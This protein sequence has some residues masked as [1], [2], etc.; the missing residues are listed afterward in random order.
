MKKI[1]KSLLLSILLILI[2]ATTSY[3]VLD[4]KCVDDASN[5]LD[6]KLESLITCAN[7][8]LYE[9]TGA[10]I[11]VV[12]KNSLAGIDISEYA[13]TY[14]AEITKSSINTDKN[15]IIVI[16]KNDRISDI[17]VSNGLSTFITKDETN[18]ILSNYMV[19]YFQKSNWNLGVEKGFR[20]IV[21]LLENHYSIDVIVDT[22]E[23][24]GMSKESNLELTNGI[25]LL[26]YSA[27]FVI[28]FGGLLYTFTHGS[29]IKAY[30]IKREG[31]PYSG[32]KYKKNSYFGFFPYSE[33]IQGEGRRKEEK[34]EKH[35]KKEKKGVSR[36]VPKKSKTKKAK[37]KDT[38]KD[39]PKDFFDIYKY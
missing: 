8:D 10:T 11:T 37:G 19:P 30:G 31:N 1:S 14:E 35:S 2:V 16:S 33:E 13:K 20:E 17:F 23:I 36:I 25:K 39:L 32:Y 29:S 4:I 5:I 6:K 38:D 28:F 7:N 34:P 18:R 3:A 9:K 15:I 21:K 22:D 24:E 26:T 12:T 27:L